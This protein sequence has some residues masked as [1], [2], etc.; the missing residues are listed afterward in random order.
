MIRKILVVLD[1]SKHSESA[2]RHALELARLHGAKVTGMGIVDV[3]GIE[4]ASVYV[5]LGASY[6]KKHLDEVKE[7]EARQRVTYLLDQFEQE[8]TK[9]GVSVEKLMKV[10]TPVKRIYLDSLFSDIIVMG[11]KTYLA[12]GSGKENVTTLRDLA[13]ETIRPIIAVPPTYRPVKEIL[14]ATDFSPACSR[15]S[16]F[17]SHV[18]L[19]PGARFHTVSFVDDEEDLQ[20]G[21]DLAAQGEG[22]LSAHGLDVAGTTVKV[23]NPREEILSFA[24]EMGADMIGLGI[25][26]K[27]SLH[28]RIFG[29]TIERLIEHSGVP[30]LMYQ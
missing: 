8:C 12:H 20:Q 11:L 5:P 6:F 29:S 1:G 18:P 26:S 15:L 21:M 7:A 25:H 9:E 14:L 19:C 23:G 28:D 2:T 27:R 16:Y 22:F 4:R 10:G 30:L 24:L 3:E 13:S 17:L